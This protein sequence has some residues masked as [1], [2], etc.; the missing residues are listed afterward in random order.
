VTTAVIEQPPPQI[1][2]NGIPILP[3]YRKPFDS[4]TGKAASVKAQIAIAAKH[5][6]VLKPVVPK[7]QSQQALTAKLNSVRRAFR[8]HIAASTAATKGSEALQ[9]ARAA[10][11]CLSIERE[12]M[13]EVK[14]HKSTKKPHLHSVAPSA[15]V[16]PLPS[17]NQG[18]NPTSACPATEQAPIAPVSPI[19]PKS[20]EID[21]CPF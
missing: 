11:E 3:G 8:R 18:V 10:R 21:D 14:S 7:G 20:P 6:N 16:E 9:H 4:V 1:D 12:L 2:E 15:K 17:G 13:G 19:P 5:F